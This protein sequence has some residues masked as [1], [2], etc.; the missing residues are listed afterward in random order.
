VVVDNTGHSNEPA[1]FLKLVRAVPEK[2]VYFAEDNQD[3]TRT[4][5]A[6]Q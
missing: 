6:A 2:N 4:K 5:D 1:D 3:E